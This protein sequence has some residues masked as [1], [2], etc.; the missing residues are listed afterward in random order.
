MKKDLKIIIIFL[1]YYFVLVFFGL[2]K[3]TINNKKLTEDAL[4]FEEREKLVAY[5]ECLQNAKIDM[6]EEDNNLTE[7]LKQY[8]VSVKYYDANNRWN[9]RCS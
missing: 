9:V 2:G 7:F 5:N 8:N 3:I 1:I 6:T 4:T